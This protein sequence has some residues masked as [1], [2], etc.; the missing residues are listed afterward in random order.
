MPL[1]ARLPVSFSAW[2]CFPRWF[3]GRVSSAG[4]GAIVVDDKS[5]TEKDR[6][7][8]KDRGKLLRPH[9]PLDL[10][11]YLV[12]R[13]IVTWFEVSCRCCWAALLFVI[14]VGRSCCCLLLFSN[15]VVV[16]LDMLQPWMTQKVTVL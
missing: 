1:V 2:Y 8:G 10:H 16:L 12:G 15:P 9:P 3:T 6:E 7:E 4:F 11:I 14:V 5:R 13:D